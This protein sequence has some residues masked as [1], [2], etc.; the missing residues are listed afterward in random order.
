MG[1]TKNVNQSMVFENH[2][3]SLI[4][5]CE[6][7]CYVYILNGQKFIKNAKN[8]RRVFEHL[9]SA[10]KQ[11]YQTRMAKNAKIHLRHFDG[12]SYSVNIANNVQNDFSNGDFGHLYLFIAVWK[13]RLF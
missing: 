13:T 6:R 8:G 2:R 9:K 1:F 11:C 4:Q 3:K 7:S 5:H 10:V 12:F